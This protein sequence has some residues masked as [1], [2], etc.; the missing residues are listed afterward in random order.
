M[1]VYAV[2]FAWEL[3][4]FDKEITVPCVADSKPDSLPE[5]FVPLITDLLVLN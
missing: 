4:D 3:Q 5:I 2:I 1:N